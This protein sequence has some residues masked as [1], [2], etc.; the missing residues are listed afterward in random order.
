MPTKLRKQR[1]AAPKGW[2]EQHSEEAYTILIKR[3]ADG[4]VFFS[5]GRF[6]YT[7]KEAQQELN[8]CR[9]HID[10]SRSKIVRVRIEDISKEKTK[11]NRRRC[12]RC[13]KPMRPTSNPFH[14]VYDCECNENS[15]G[16]CD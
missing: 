13:R 10:P 16:E 3:K 15:R 2:P 8:D 14:F 7:K 5:H 9:K 6:V 12:E 1:L 4:V 11:Q